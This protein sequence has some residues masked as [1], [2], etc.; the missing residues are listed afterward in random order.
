MRRETHCRHIGYSFP[1]AARVLLYAPSQDNIYHSL[2][3]TNRGA[4]AG[5]REKKQKQ[6][7]QCIF[8]DRHLLIRVKLIKVISTFLFARIKT[9]TLLYRIKICCEGSKDLSTYKPF[10]KQHY[11]LIFSHLSVFLKQCRFLPWIMLKIMVLFRQ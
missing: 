9:S 8:C 5:T 10:L 3:Y 11:N 7:A 6:D 4:L 2:W 1:L